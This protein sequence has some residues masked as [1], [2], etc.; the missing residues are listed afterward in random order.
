MTSDRVTAIGDGSSPLIQG[1]ACAALQPGL[2]SVLVFDSSPQAL[3]SAANVLTEMLT[4]T[5]D[6]AV[7]QMTLGRADSDETLWGTWSLKSGALGE[8]FDWEAGLLGVGLKVVLI[9][10]LT[11]LSLVAARACI[12]LM[13]TE[14]AQVERH[15]YQAR[16]RSEIC[17]IAGCARSDIGMVSPHL[18]DRFALRLPGQE[19]QSIDRT[20]AL[21][22]WFTEL[23]SSPDES[24]RLSPELCDRLRAATS[25]HPTIAPD[26]YERALAYFSDDPGM[27][28]RRELALMRFAQARS[29]WAGVEQ[30]S[31]REVDRT[32]QAMGLKLTSLPSLPKPDL[33]ELSPVEPPEPIETPTPTPSPSRSDLPKPAPE[34][35][36]VYRSD[37]EVTLP[38]TNLDAMGDRENPYPEDDAALQ[39][40][41]ASLRLPPRRF[42]AAKGGRGAIIGT[43]PA[44]IPQDIAWVS[45]LL[46]AAKYQ[47]FRQERSDQALVVRSTDLRRYRRAIV[48]EQLL[49]V[50]LD[51]TCLKDCQWQASVWPYL[52]WAY[53]ER[54]S[55]C[56]VQV[57]AIG[58]AQELQAQRISGQSIL[59]PRIRSGLEAG[60]GRATPLAHGL[61]LACQTLRHALQ[62]GRNGVQR[63]V[64][65]VV[66][67]GRG[68]VPLESSRLNQKPTQPV[69][70]RGIEDALAIAADIQ[71]LNQVEA[72][73]LNPQPKYYADL[74]VKLA[75]A[76][77]A[78][79]AD[80]PKQYDWEVEP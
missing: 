53:V 58:A 9:P 26:A 50:V 42:Q 67:D 34:K 79:I 56:L 10:D 61:D 45:T 13:G 11:R 43:E 74:P 48:P 12:A 73:V 80:I 21:R 33:P 19:I 25:I 15:G 24:A 71:R 8:S 29:Q 60:A 49:M 65:V 63:A 36:E 62:H 1:L 28:I 17:W 41:F 52:Q 47:A 46:E 31:A 7:K 39:R 18:L 77:G 44:T 70:R 2:R 59:V 40:E 72:I 32:A 27:G 35:A 66:S 23:E 3:R 20:D 78:T 22:D 16:W 30:L 64:L 14:I 51:Y 54:A 57:G 37:S 55:V 69:K 38:P 75:Q 6:R 4:V 76:L 68:N 5:S